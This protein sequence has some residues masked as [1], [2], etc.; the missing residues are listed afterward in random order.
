MGRSVALD[1]NGC[2]RKPG[3]KSIVRVQLK[4][5]IKWGTVT[6]PN[7]ELNQGQAKRSMNIKLN[8]FV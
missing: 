7:V 2:D 5:R 1:D 3:H 8:C 6:L 4:E